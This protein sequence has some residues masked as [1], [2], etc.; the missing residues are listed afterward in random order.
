MTDAI[1]APAAN[2]DALPTPAEPTPPAPLFF[3]GLDDG[4]LVSDATVCATLDG[5]S[6]MKLY[7]LGKSDPTFPAPYRIGSMN[8]RV[9]GEMR[10]WLVAQRRQRNDG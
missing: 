6:R 10:R 9:V 5:C 8:Y 7:R 1:A 4:D 3:T 2:D